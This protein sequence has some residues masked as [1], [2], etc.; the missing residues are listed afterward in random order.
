MHDNG[1]TEYAA[2]YLLTTYGKQTE[3]ILELYAQIKVE[4]LLER[5]IRA[6]AQFTIAHEMALNPLD[7]FIRR[8]GRLYFD[9]DSVRNFMEPVFEEFQKAYGYS[10][11]EMDIFKK[12]LEEELESHSNFSL[13]RA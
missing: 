2:W 7:F 12:E 13:D 10:S 4:N 5:M 8:T 1:F 6:E 3:N 9:I 11:E